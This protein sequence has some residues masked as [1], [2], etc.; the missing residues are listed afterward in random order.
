MKE[1]SHQQ[2]LNARTPAISGSSPE[3]PDYQKSTL[4]EDDCTLALFLC[5]V[6][7]QSLLAM[8]RHR[9]LHSTAI[10]RP[11]VSSSKFQHN[12]TISMSVFQ[13]YIQLT[14]VISPKRSRTHLRT[15]PEPGYLAQY[16]FQL[17][18]IY[19]SRHFIHSLTPFLFKN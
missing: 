5:P 16:G 12:F 18:K 7:G 2:V 17:C 15:S 3:I 8:V 1:K 9:I 11:T 10:L 19:I 13:Y 4:W 6:I 14:E